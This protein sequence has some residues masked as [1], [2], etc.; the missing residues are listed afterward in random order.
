[1][2]AFHTT[3]AIG[4]PLEEVFGYLSDPTNFPAWN[5]AVQAVRPTFQG[6]GRAGSTYA[7]ERQLPTGRATNQLEIV[8]HEQ[9][10]EFA[11][12]TTAGPTPFLYRYRFA[13]ENRETVVRLDAQ[14]ELP[15]IAAFVPG[16]AQRA[17]KKGV[18]ENLATLKRILEERPSIG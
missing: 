17:V 10:R 13:A 1:M 7:M 2:I 14:V 15:R 12:R 18:D 5:S 6:K 4:R 8:T 9:P 11:I 16:L 3:V